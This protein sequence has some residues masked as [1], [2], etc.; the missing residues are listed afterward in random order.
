MHEPLHEQVVAVV[1][2]RGA[3]GATTAAMATLMGLPY[4]TA[5]Q[6]CWRAQA[7]GWITS[8]G[9]GD[10]RLW[11]SHEGRAGQAPRPE[12]ALVEVPVRVC[13]VQRRRGK[14]RVQQ[15]DAVEPPERGP[16]RGV[17]WA[18]AESFADEW[19]RLRGGACG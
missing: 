13:P 16:A 7:R 2:S 1:A 10:A 3:L 9:R 8:R 19:R 11:M 17:L 6:A 18:P 14:A 15:L 5:Y 4:R 12:R